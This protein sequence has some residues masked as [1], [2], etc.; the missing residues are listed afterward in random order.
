M[1]LLLDEMYAPAVALQLRT[2]GHDVVAVA[3]RTELRNRPDPEVFE[4]AQTER[5][6]IVTENIRDY[7]PIAAGWDRHGRLHHGLVLVHRGRYPRGAA[8]TIG[9]LVTELD[10]LLNRHATDEPTSLRHWL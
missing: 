9:R 1:R 10:R 7:V 5:R 3:D 4:A 6:A 8:K 2:R